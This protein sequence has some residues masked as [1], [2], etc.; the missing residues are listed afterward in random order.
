MSE[1]LISKSEGLVLSRDC[2]LFQPGNVD[3]KE[4]TILVQTICHLFPRTHTSIY[5]SALCDV[6]KVE[7]GNPAQG[8]M[9]VLLAKCPARRGL[10]Q[11]SQ[12]SRRDAQWAGLKKMYWCRQIQRE[13]EWADANAERKAAAAEFA[14]EPY[15]KE[16]RFAL[17]PSCSAFK[18]I[19]NV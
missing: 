12:V 1:K 10:S 18:S 16:V 13:K 19:S 17:H 8:L 6:F 5:I 7:S 2:S 15:H 11:S 4:F 9:L 14:G 3:C